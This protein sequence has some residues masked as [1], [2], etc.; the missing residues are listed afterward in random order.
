[1]LCRGLFGAGKTTSRKG[2]P[3]RC[4]CHRTDAAHFSFDA[5]NNNCFLMMISEPLPGC[6]RREWEL[7]TQLS[8]SIA[9]AQTDLDARQRESCM[10]FHITPAKASVCF[11][12]LGAEGAHRG[13]LA[14]PEASSARCAV[15]ADTRPGGCQ[16]A[17]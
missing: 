7:G 5:R 1:M 4:R 14:W 17:V 6:C 10:Q 11:E 15:G 16:S 2:M 8:Q 13:H 12:T 9:D 3:G